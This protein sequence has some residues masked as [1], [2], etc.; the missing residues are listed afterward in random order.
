M[1]LFSAPKVGKSFLALDLARA[2][3]QGDASWL[4]QVILRQAR[5][6]YFQLDTPRSLWIDRIKKLQAAGIS[7]ATNDTSPETP[8][9]TNFFFIADMESAPFPF[10]IHTQECFDWLKAQTD[11]LKPELIIID[12]MREVHDLD[13]DKATPMKSVLTT[14]RAACMP[15]EGP[16]PAI[17]LISHS[18]KS[19]PKHD[20]GLMDEGRGANYVAGRADVVCRM[21]AKEGADTC[22]LVYRGR[23][24][25]HDVKILVRN[26][27]TILW[28]LKDDPM[29]AAKAR[30]KA[31]VEFIARNPVHAKKTLAERGR[32][33]N[34]LH[35]DKS[36][37]TCTAAIRRY[38]EP[39]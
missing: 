39:C 37:Q 3:S 38:K 13:E 36:H 19:N 16:P 24:T 31:D 14:I 21:L 11:T 28:E 8:S 10:N 26:P 15:T 2:V 27:K 7:F 18:R 34:A 35:T 30:W 5:V 25:G 32:I 4:N 6:L 33:L 20:G 23:A 1:N 12:T 9:A 17:I 29:A 22:R